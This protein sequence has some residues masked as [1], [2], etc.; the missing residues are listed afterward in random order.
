MLHF[1]NGVRNSF[2]CL[3]SRRGKE[4]NIQGAP[5][6]S[7]TSS[8]TRFYGQPN[9]HSLSAKSDVVHQAIDSDRLRACATKHRQGGSNRSFVL[10]LFAK[11]GGQLLFYGCKIN[12]SIKM[13]APVDFD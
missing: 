4:R 9:A 8:Q 13:E 1:R 3:S 5:I 11:K 10:R 12:V 6:F 2:P 7:A